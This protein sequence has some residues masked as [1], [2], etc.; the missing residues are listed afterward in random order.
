LSVTKT[1]VKDKQVKI[2]I[3]NSGATDEVI[4]ALQLTWPFENGKLVQ[5]KRDG[6]V[7]YDNPDIAAP[8]ANLTLAQL[9]TDVN[10]RTIKHGTSDVLTLVFEKNAS[11]AI[12]GYTGTLTTT[13]VVLTILP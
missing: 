3:T 1:E 6:D 11:L 9:V 5:V 2:T 12:A 7:I 13:G 4:N 10:R 8:S